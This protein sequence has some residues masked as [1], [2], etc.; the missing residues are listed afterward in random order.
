MTNL[1]TIN[2]VRLGADLRSCNHCNVK[3]QTF[4]GVSYQTSYQTSLS[5]LPNKHCS[6]ATQNK[7]SFSLMYSKLSL[8]VNV[9]TSVQNAYAVNHNLQNNNV[10]ST[11]DT[12]VI[13]HVLLDIPCMTILYQ[14]DRHTLEM[15][16]FSHEDH[17]H[18]KQTCW[19]FM[20]TPTMT[21]QGQWKLQPLHSINLTR[22]PPH[23]STN[24]STVNIPHRDMRLLSRSIHLTARQTCSL[25][26]SAWKFPVL[27]NTPLYNAWSSTLT[28][29][30]V[31]IFTIMFK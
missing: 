11:C 27:T 22:K 5:S 23:V 12:H 15:H 16:L 8:P 29:N 24:Q 13:Q 25:H 17:K 30:N 19:H 28:D 9:H 21:Q 26:E 4:K 20:C 6:Q 1:D 7:C 10:N 2:H 14:N 3:A 31:V 18:H